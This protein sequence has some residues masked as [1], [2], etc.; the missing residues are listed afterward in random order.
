CLEPYRQLVE[1]VRSAAG[2]SPKSRTSGAASSGTSASPSSSTAATLKGCRRALRRPTG[3]SSACSRRRRRGLR[4]GT[5][6][7]AQAVWAFAMMDLQRRLG[8][9]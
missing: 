1:L 9:D 5:E 6:P 3:C 4:A 8:G 2:P 7:A